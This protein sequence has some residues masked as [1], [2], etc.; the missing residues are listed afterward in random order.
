MYMA[1]SSN[2]ILLSLRIVS[3]YNSFGGRDSGHGSSDA[4][5]K[6]FC[7]RTFNHVCLSKLMH[8]I[9]SS[10]P[11]SIRMHC[12]SECSWSQSQSA[13]GSTIEY[14]FG[15]LS[16]STMGGDNIVYSEDIL[17][18]EEGEKRAVR[19]STIKG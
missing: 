16:D 3:D 12:S 14:K 18:E 17:I 8:T 10:T 19:S 15:I 6:Q 1:P 11:S 7:R 13:R 4:C 5:T 9:T 2:D